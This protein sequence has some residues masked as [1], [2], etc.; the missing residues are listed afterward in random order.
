MRLQSRQ[1]PGV[2][3]LHQQFGG[4]ETLASELVRRERPQPA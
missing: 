3:S 1:L 2:D 4:P